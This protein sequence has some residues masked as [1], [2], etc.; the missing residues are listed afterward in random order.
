VQRREY[1]SVADDLQA[2]AK[3][4]VDDVNAVLRKY[5]LSSP[6]TV[7]VGP[8]ASVPRPT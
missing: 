2:V 4:S 1:R 5:P 8:L 7:T 6:T 3:L